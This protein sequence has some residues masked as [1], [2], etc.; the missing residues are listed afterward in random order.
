[1]RGGLLALQIQFQEHGQPSKIDDLTKLASI[2]EKE[3]GQKVAE[4]GESISKAIHWDIINIYC[5]EPV[6]PE[7]IAKKGI[8]G[9]TPILLF[10]STMKLVILVYTFFLM[11]ETVN[12]QLILLFSVFVH[13]TTLCHT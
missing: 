6:L 3:L 7:D 11:L 13:A 12:I 10:C 2:D 8:L 4:T 1:M 5:S 9:V